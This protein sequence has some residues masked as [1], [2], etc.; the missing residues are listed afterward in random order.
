[1]YRFPI[2]PKDRNALLGARGGQVV[3]GRLNARCGDE[4]EVRFP[5]LAETL[6]VNKARAILGLGALECF[7][8]VR[9]R[10]PPPGENP[11]DFLAALGSQRV[12][13]SCLLMFRK[14]MQRLFD[15]FS[16]KPASRWSASLHYLSE[17]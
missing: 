14:V 8:I 10:G 7:Q 13:K 5:M 6:A 15:V 17:G 11:T 9:P 2:R 3:V 12:D 1:M 4:A 16:A